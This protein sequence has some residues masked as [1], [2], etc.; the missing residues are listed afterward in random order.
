LSPSKQELFQGRKTTTKP[1]EATAKRRRSQ[2]PA[3][4]ETAKATAETT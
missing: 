1:A 2:G 3:A 4:A